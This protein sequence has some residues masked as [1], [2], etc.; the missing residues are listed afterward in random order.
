MK[1]SFSLIVL[2]CFTILSTF[3][4]SEVDFQVGADG[5][6]SHA[7]YYSVRLANLRCKTAPCPSHKLQRVNTQDPEVDII[8]F[9]F[10]LLSTMNKSHVHDSV[11]NSVL[12]EGVFLNSLLYPGYLKF[13]VVNYHVLLPQ[14][15]TT[16]VAP[17][18]KY[19]KLSSSGIYCYKWPCPSILATELNTGIVNVVTGFNEPYSTY[20]A[21]FD[22]NWL[23]SRLFTDTGR[24]QAII[25]GPIVPGVENSNDVVGTQVY[26]DLPDP[27]STC[28]PVTKLYCLPELGQVNVY[29]RD[30]NRCI[31]SDGCAN[32][33]FCTLQI[34][35]CPN[36]YRRTGHKANPNGC[37]KW[38]C[39]FELLSP[40]N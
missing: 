22:S 6:Y 34:P 1:L 33:G 7:G 21:F 36:G 35:E 37:F 5:F 20:V 28:P 27:L 40:T 9:E 14:G 24:H 10:P 8:G 17:A 3:G 12:V 25:R 23:Y 29:T 18:G 31:V 19:F 13:Y 39:D 11:D 4:T 16:Q 2:I 15:D 38:N 26:V 32:E 30:S